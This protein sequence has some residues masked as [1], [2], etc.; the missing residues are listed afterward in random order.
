MTYGLYILVTLVQA[1]IS[2][3]LLLVLGAV[4]LAAVKDAMQENQNKLETLSDY[5]TNH[6]EN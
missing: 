2:I 4:I 6:K 1:M 5:I 3:S